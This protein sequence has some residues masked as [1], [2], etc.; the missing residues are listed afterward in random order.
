MSEQDT[1]LGILNS[2]LTTPHRDL[3]PI[4]KVHEDYV[5]GDPLF[6]QRMAAWYCAKG[7][8]RDLKEVFVIHLC[9][10]TY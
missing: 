4:Y 3:M 6:Y 9:L 1:R 2:I 10:S 7:D 8:I 5:T